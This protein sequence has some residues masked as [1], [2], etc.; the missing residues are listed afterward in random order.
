MTTFFV[1]LFKAIF[2]SACTMLFMMM[3]YA[4]VR[5]RNENAYVQAIYAL[6]LAVCAL[7][8]LTAAIYVVGNSRMDERDKWMRR[9]IDREL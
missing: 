1:R 6:V 3:V 9:R 5:L 7:G 4:F 2:A 8:L